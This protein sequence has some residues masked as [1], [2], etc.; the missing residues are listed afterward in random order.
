MAKEL[1]AMEARRSFGS[2]LDKAFY[3]KQFTVIKRAN[4]PMA[5]LM[6]YDFLQ[7]IEVYSKE[8]TEKIQTVAKE[9]N[10]SYEEALELANQATHYVRD[11]KN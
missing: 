3:Q 4:K 1:D 6:P 5:V 2:L 11:R 9:N 8:L 7:A 10:L